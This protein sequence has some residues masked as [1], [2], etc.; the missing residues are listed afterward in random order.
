MQQVEDYG[1]NQLPFIIVID[2][3][4]QVYDVLNGKEELQKYALA[5]KIKNVLAGGSF[6]NSAAHKVSYEQAYRDG[7]LAIKALDDSK[8][9]F[10]EKVLK[11]F[12]YVPKLSISV[13]RKRIFD[14]TGQMIEK[15]YDAKPLIQINARRID[16]LKIRA[17]LEEKLSGVAGGIDNFEFKEQLLETFTVP[18]G[19]KCA[20]CSAAIDSTKR[21]YW[22]FHK[23]EHVCRDCAE[24]E[25]KSKELFGERFKYH[26]NLVVIEIN[27][28]TKLLENIDEHKFGKDTQPPLE[29]KFT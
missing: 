27:G 22:S 11:D 14:Y 1:L 17:F 2:S 8:S 15:I 21:H 19:D 10:Q 29:D 9:E 16:Y 20:V 4:Q 3:H 26:H 5:D 7:K 23:K 13:S 18:L 6:D 25:D 28:N 24:F 12:Q